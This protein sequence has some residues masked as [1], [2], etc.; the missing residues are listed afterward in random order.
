MTICAHPE[1]D[2]V[3]GCPYGYVICCIDCTNKECDAS[4]MDKET[5]PYKLIK[6]E[7]NE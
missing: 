1:L 6:D 4:C 2:V 3:N 5:C 7:D